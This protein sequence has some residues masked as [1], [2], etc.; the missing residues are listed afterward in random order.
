MGEPLTVLLSRMKQGDPIARDALFAAAYAQ[1]R[2]LAHARLYGGGR[3]TVLDTT[4]LVHESYLRLVQTR[5]LNIE[6]RRAFFAYASQVMRSV[7]VEQAAHA[8]KLL[9]REF[10]GLCAAQAWSRITRSSMR[11]FSQSRCTVR[12]VTSSVSAISLT[13]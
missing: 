5:E 12:S 10:H 3:N 11:A 1:L 8:R 9:G 13:L 6:D 2:R 7:I 4:A